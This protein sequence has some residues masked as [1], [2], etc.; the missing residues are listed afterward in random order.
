MGV[1]GM[2][3]RAFEAFKTLKV[4]KEKLNNNNQNDYFYLI[5]VKSMPKFIKIIQKPDC[6]NYINNKTSE[7]NLNK[8]FKYYQKEK[9]SFLTNFNDC[10][11]LAEQN[12]EE[13]N[14]FIIVEKSFIDKMGINIDNKKI[15]PIIVENNKIKCYNS[16]RKI[17]FTN[18][19]NILYK[20]TTDGNE[21]LNNSTRKSED[22]SNKFNPDAKII[23]NNGNNEKETNVDKN[24]SNSNQE[25]KTKTAAI[26]NN[27]NEKL[28]NIKNSIKT[29]I[30]YDNNVNQLQENEKKINY[31]RSINTELELDNASI[32][33]N[34]N[35]QFQNNVEKMNIQKSIQTLLELD[36]AKINNNIYQSQ[37]NNNQNQINVHKSIR[38]EIE[39][40]K[41]SF[42]NSFNQLLNNENNNVNNR[43]LFDEEI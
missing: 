8:H 5:K 16:S 38:T 26:Y 11:R 24:E 43:K 9:S 28:I 22:E 31:Q 20:F 14:K 29:E 3:Y 1:G 41:D 35:N 6:I 4:T 25:T 7:E 19:E 17:S 40:D 32:K 23:Q 18:I 21:S 34:N 10:W 2:S 39:Y 36:N 12:I 42:N 33:N 15:E 30:E 37:N 13:E 27:E